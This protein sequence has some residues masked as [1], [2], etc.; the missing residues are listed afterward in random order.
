MNFRKVLVLMLC[1]VVLS[2]S[3]S[4]VSATD[5]SIVHGVEKVSNNQ[6]IEYMSIIKTATN[7][8]PISI[9]GIY[10]DNEEILY[11]VATNDD[12]IANIPMEGIN[13][14]LTLGDM[15]GFNEFLLNN[16]LNNIKFSM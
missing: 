7:N 9:E 15:F 14:D 8:E 5:Y 11:F 12:S 2:L 10:S 4:C 3:F 16:Y 1:L 6:P 13:S